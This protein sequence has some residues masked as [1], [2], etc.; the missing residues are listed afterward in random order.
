MRIAGGC[1]D[2]HRI[3]GN[4]RHCSAEGA[5]IVDVYLTS[6]FMDLRS[7]ICEYLITTKRKIYFNSVVYIRIKVLF[8][9]SILEPDFFI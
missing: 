5:I 3:V 4:I 2:S 7:K 8:S 1:G 6:K 9:V